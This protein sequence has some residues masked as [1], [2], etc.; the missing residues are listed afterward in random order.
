MNH[1]ATVSIKTE[2]QLIMNQKKNN[3]FHVRALI[4]SK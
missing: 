3:I 1:K 4:N 2:Y